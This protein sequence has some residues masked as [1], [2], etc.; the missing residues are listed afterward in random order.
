MN[1]DDAAVKLA[2]ARV[3]M[4]T[5][6]VNRAQSL[7]HSLPVDISMSPEVKRLQAEIEFAQI[8]SEVDYN[9]ADLEQSISTDPDNLQARY[10]LGA[11]KV[12][13]WRL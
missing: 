13:R 9:E 11:K 10:R 4:L 7:L 8:A 3:F 12:L 5:G 1:P 6:A 2:T